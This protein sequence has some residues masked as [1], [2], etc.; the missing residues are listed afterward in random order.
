MTPSDAG[1]SRP[2]SSPNTNGDSPSTDHFP[3]NIYS[4]RRR[5]KEVRPRAGERRLSDS[6]SAE[7]TQASP[8]GHDY[9]ALRSLRRKT[10]SIWS[11]HL[12]LDRRASRY[13]VWDPPSVSWSAD[14]GILGHRNAQ[15]VLFI[16]GFLIPFGKAQPVI[17]VGYECHVC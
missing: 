5:A 15:V 8:L 3:L 16:A 10:S 11:P 17:R 14:T 6:G 1:D 13:S 4:S 2:G 9:G 12:R 7:I